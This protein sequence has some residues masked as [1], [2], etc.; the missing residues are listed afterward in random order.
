MAFQILG[1]KLHK[2]TKKS[3][4]YS[5]ILLIFI[6][7]N[8]VVVRHPI[9]REIKRFT[10]AH[11]DTNAKHCLFLHEQLIHLH[12]ENTQTKLQP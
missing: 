10:M 5:K 3:S 7:R 6:H 12:T 8:L 11:V 1:Q 2:N 9:T 4:F